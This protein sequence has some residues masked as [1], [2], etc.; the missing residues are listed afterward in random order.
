MAHIDKCMFSQRVTN[1]AHDDIANIAGK[2]QAS[3]ADAVCSAG[4]LCI[5]SAL[6]N[7]AAYGSAIKNGN[8]WIMVE[9]EDDSLATDG[10]YACNTYNVNEV[11]GA[12]GNVYKIGQNTL[13]LDLPAGEI[14]AWTKIDFLSGDKIYRFGEGNLDGAI[15][16]NTFFTITDGMLTPAAAAPSGTVGL[17]YFELVGT[18]TITEGTYASITYYDVVA[19]VAMA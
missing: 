14:G 1:A 7:T 16:T 19:K 15:S 18:G 17:P 3:A 6:M 4:F 2:F 10:I 12:N 9:A 11:V 8:T 13:G 5:R